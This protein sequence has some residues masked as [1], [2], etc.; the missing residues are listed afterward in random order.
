[1]RLT[2]RRRPAWLKSAAPAP[3]DGSFQKRYWLHRSI[4]H[5]LSPSDCVTTSSPDSSLQLR[6]PDRRFSSSLRSKLAFIW[7]VC[8]H[9]F[10]GLD[11]LRRR[12]RFT[13]LRPGP[14]CS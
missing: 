12:N 7:L 6:T 2:D 14:P 4:A 8:R 13:S 1:P 9:C 10:I 11:R 5:G 3:P